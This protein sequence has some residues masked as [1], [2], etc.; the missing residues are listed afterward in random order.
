MAFALTVNV[1]RDGKFLGDHFLARSVARTRPGRGVEIRSARETAN[2]SADRRFAA[3]LSSAALHH[4]SFV[5]IDRVVALPGSVVVTL[6]AR[7]CDSDRLAAMATLER[8][9]RGII[10]I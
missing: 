4:L 10:A 1:E 2:K 3:G 5:S 9:N 7:H 8:P 6:D